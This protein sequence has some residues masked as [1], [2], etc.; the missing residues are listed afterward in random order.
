M[1]DVA[2]KIHNLGQETNSRLATILQT[3]N[4]TLRDRYQYRAFCPNVI[5]L[6]WQSLCTT[7]LSRRVKEEVDIDE[8]ELEVDVED[9]DLENAE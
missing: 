7:L 2:A 1:R 9:E 3:Y 4:D 8:T 5:R 6:V